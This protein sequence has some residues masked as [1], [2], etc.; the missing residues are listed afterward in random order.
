MQIITPPSSSGLTLATAVA[1]TSGTVA[2]F[3]GIPSTV[4]RI[5]VMFNG[6]SINNL[7]PIRIQLGSGSIDATGYISS[8]GV[9]LDT[10]S[11]GAVSSTTGFLINSSGFEAAGLYSGSAIL[12]LMG[13]NIWVMQSCLGA[14]LSSRTFFSGGSKTLSGTLD[15]LRVTTNGTHLFDAG[16]I[17][18]MYE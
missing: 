12:T 4:K 2:D 15:I 9:I 13:S 18:I 14:I 1:T 6:V 5:T 17:N 10:P 3:T 11:Y 8:S 16:S 7:G